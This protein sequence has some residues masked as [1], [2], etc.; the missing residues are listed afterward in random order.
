MDFDL[1]SDFP[2]GA[3]SVEFQLLDQNFETR[4]CIHFD[5]NVVDPPAVNLGRDLGSSSV[6]SSATW[7]RSFL[8]MTQYHSRRHPSSGGSIV[9]VQ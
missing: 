7:L 8:E 9:L 4:A 3:A 6:S 5:I 1:P 2:L